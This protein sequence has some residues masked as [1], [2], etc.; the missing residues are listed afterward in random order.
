M[1]LIRLYQEFTPTTAVYPDIQEDPSII[2]SMYC[3]LGLVGEAGE[4]AEKIKKWHRDG[5][6]DKDALVKEIGDVLWYCSE[7][8]NNLDISLE[9]VIITNRDKLIDRNNRNVIKGEGDNR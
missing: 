7:L 2:K 3:A 8:C 5:R 9:Q 6:L 4:V 1:S